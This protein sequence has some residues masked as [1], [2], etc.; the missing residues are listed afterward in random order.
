[1]EISIKD[2]E[3][4]QSAEII[5]FNKTDK[6]YRTKLLSMGLT[7]GTIIKLVKVAPLGDPIDIEVRDYNLTLRKN[8]AEILKIRRV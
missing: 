4:N 1:M 8:E 2:L 3:I 6:T 5:G 7:K